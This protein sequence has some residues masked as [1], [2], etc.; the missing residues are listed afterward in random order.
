MTDAVTKR[1]AAIV[2]FSCGLVFLFGIS[3]TQTRSQD[4]PP[5]AMKTAQSCS[6]DLT[7][8][9]TMKDIV[10]NALI[11]TLKQPEDQVKAFLTGAEKQFATGQEL[12]Q[13][14]ARHFSVS[15][16]DLNAAVI[17]WKH[18]NCQ[19]AL[20]V[21]SVATP[22]NQPA[23]EAVQDT[24]TANVSKFAQ[25]VTLHVVLHELGHAI[26][27][28]FDLPVLGNEETLADAFATIYLT[29]HMSDRALEILQARTQSLM[30]E[31]N[32]VPRDQWT[33]RG[34][35]NNDA[36]R[37]YQIVALALAADSEKYASLANI[38]GMS[39]RDISNSRDY[40]AEIHR[41]WR[42]LLQ[43]FWMPDGVESPETRFI[44]DTEN[45]IV[46]QLRA[47]GITKELE[48]AVS[49]FDWHSQITIHFANGDG[50]AGWSR[51]KRTI[52]VNSEYVQRFIKQGSVVKK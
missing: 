45:P 52:T 44:Y 10:S 1:G 48:T 2:A 3:A 50:G 36:R 6:V 39:E 51:S 4:A 43:P 13:A 38:V 11:L 40:G 20:D 22:I 31:A 42:R 7:N 15:E 47:S 27:R 32:E 9:A 14:A 23:P 33:V 21:V 30:I 41:S 28:E 24:P 35:H 5:A 18:C 25:D 49:R 16:V 26:V 8:P 12:L 46:N 37:A 34:E 29:N 17:K 19:H